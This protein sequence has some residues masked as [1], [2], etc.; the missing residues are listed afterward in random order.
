MSS[1]VLPKY[2]GRR[3]ID[4]GEGADLGAH[5]LGLTGGPHPL[6]GDIADRHDDMIVVEPRT[7]R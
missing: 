1:L 4:R 6:A 7:R 5:G 2:E 3:R